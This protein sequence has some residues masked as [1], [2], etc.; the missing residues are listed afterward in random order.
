MHQVKSAILDLNPEH[1]FWLILTLN[2]P[3]SSLFS[4]YILIIKEINDLDIGVLQWHHCFCCKVDIPKW[5]LQLGMRAISASERGFLG[6]FFLRSRCKWTPGA[7]GH[8]ISLRTLNPRCL[9]ELKHHCYASY[10]D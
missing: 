5:I 4:Q 7:E 2:Y 10:I 3:K 6:H 9:E 1:L 8:H